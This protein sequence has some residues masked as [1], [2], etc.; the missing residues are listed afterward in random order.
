[1]EIRIDKFLWATRIFKS[2]SQA[3]EA[4][5]KG[6]I[7]INDNIVKP[8]HNVKVNDIIKVKKNTIIYIYRVKELIGNRIS[9]KLTDQFIINL[10][11]EEEMMKLKSF[12]SSSFSF[13]EKGSGRPTKKERRL[14]D[15][16]FDKNL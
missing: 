8:S 7:L 11:P 3:T 2:R 15:D 13:R 1:M 4:C 6:K 10:T 9:A 16:F 12:A 5:T 14:I